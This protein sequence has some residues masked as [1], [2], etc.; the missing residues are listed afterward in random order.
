MHESAN[1]DG[2]ASIISTETPTIDAFIFF[3]TSNPADQRLATLDYPH[4]PILS[5]V[6]C[7]GLFAEYDTIAV[8]R[9]SHQPLR[10]PS[11]SHSKSANPTV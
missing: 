11:I 1:A 10:K 6:R 4:R 9:E 3:L 7:I 2:A 5:R 8:S